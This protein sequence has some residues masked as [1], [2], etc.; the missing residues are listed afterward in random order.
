LTRSWWLPGLAL[1][2]V[3]VFLLLF[4]LDDRY[5]WG[6]EAETAVLARSIART[7]LPFVRHEGN[8]ITLLGG[9]DSNSHGLWTWSPWLD[10]YVAAGAFLLLGESIW[11]ARVP[12]A[13]VGL[14]CICLVAWVAHRVFRDP[15][16]SFTVALLHAS[17]VAFLLHARQCRYYVL[18]ALAQVLLL[19]GF[20]Q[21]LHSRSRW[22]S[23]WVVA[24]MAIQSYTNYILVP[25]NAVVLLAA[26]VAARPRDAHVWKHA[27]LGLAASALVAAPWLLYARP[28]GQAGELGVAHFWPNLRFY[29]DITNRFVL[30]LLLL[31][32]PLAWGLAKLLRPTLETPELPEREMLCLL[33]VYPPSIIIYLCFVPLP[34][35]RYLFPALSILLLL[36][37][38]ILVRGIPW[39]WVRW[40]VLATLVF[41]DALGVVPA[42][43]FG[44]GA[45]VTSPIT[46]FVRSITT[47]YVD[48]L[49][50]VAEFLKKEGEPGQSIFVMDPEFPLMFHTRM[51]ILDGRFLGGKV[52]T[53]APDWFFSMST[54]G[55]NKESPRVPPKELA[56]RYRAIRITVP[57]NSRHA[58]RPDPRVHRYFV[59]DR[60][61]EM[62]FYKRID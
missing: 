41:S 59:P 40:T 22:R 38:L 1:G 39:R 25:I 20:H 54:S 4:N 9:A 61:E 48:R 31:L 47:E 15:E 33:A 8:F 7:G 49:E 18:T 13:F 19:H 37:S 42:R 26:S 32:V 53:P 45:P 14:L 29:L 34:F 21:L 36:A 17:N 3:A 43:L 57:D 46:R 16:V 2:L 5:L 44:M 56:D 51:R 27:L 62:V 50:T 60:T 10:E 6:D 58:T 52:P 23:G 30:P 24:G 55:L 28:F 12:F 35:F 11:S